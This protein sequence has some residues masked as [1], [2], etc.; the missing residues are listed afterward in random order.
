MAGRDIEPQLFEPNKRFWIVGPTYDLG[1]KEFRV[2]WDDLMIFMGL[3]KDKRIKKAYNK[4]QGE[5]FIEFPWQ[6]RLEVRSAQ[7]PSDLVGEALDGLIVSEAAKQ[8]KETYDRYL[9]PSLGDKRGWATFPTTPEGYNWLHEVWQLGRNPEFPDYESWQFP[10]WDNYTVYPGGRTDSE[11][12]LLEQ[13]MDEA[14]FKQEIGADFTAFSGKIFPEWSEYK[15]VEGYQFHP[16]WPNYIAFDWGFTNPLAAVEFQVSPSDD[17]YV[18]REHYLGYTMLET[19]I[20]MLKARPQPA[21]YHLDLAF[22]DAADPE[23]AMY[24]TMHLVTCIADPDAKT[25]WRQGID[26]MKKFIKLYQVG[27]DE[28]GTPIEKTKY[29]VSPA[30]P[31]VIREMN[32]YKAQENRQGLNLREESAKTDNHT[33]DAMRYALVT[34][35]ELGVMHHLSDVADLMK[36]NLYH[37]PTPDSSP[38]S[39]ADMIQETFFTMTGRDF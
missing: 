23:A 28:D 8:S 25:N 32:N 1:E 14:E 27:N 19:H 3:G 26:L 9:R 37:S 18:W 4:R 15:H 12:L 5:M 11:I 17:I 34:L 35:F 24:V 30:C 7:H 38:G 10:S 6:T 22:G 36:P 31:H 16:E 33:I 21:G 13:T 39:V 20:E 2:I 29:H